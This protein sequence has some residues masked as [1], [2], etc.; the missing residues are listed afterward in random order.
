MDCC[1][2]PDLMPEDITS[3]CKAANPKPSGPPPPGPPK[4]EKF[5]LQA[6]QVKLIYQVFQDV[7]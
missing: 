2:V 4:G 3:K 5:N 7:A 1:K 6:I